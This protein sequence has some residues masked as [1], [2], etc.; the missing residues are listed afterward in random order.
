MLFLKGYQVK[1]PEDAFV[2]ELLPEFVDSW[3]NDIENQ[4]DDLVNNG[5]FDDLYRMAHTI[6]GSCFQ[7]GLDEIA[8]L[9]IKLMEYAKNKD[10]QNAVKIKDKI[11]TLF[12]EAKEYLQNNK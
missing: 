9:G 12:Y 10:V 3:I 1:L 5:N 8:E 2:K 6:K 7:F 4:F 11:I